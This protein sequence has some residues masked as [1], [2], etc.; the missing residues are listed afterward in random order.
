MFSP[1]LFI[2][3]NWSLNQSSDLF[4]MLRSELRFLRFVLQQREYT[5]FR[6]WSCCI[7]G[8]KLEEISAIILAFGK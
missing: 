2:E 8:P 4:L 5:A 3:M 7:R 6:Y 1:V